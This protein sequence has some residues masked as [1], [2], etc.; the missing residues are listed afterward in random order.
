MKKF[1]NSSITVC[2]FYDL[3][4]IKEYAEIIQITPLEA[5]VN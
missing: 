5:S 1:M 3:K 4:Q 2:P